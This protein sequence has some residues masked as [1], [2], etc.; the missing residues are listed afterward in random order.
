M[1]G[2]DTWQ[3][4][5]LEF[6]DRIEAFDDVD[7]LAVLSFMLHA[8]R[9]RPT[10]TDLIKGLGFAIDT[11]AP[12]VVQLPLEEHLEEQEARTQF[13]DALRDVLL[14]LQAMGEEVPLELLR[15]R[16]HIPGVRF[17]RDYPAQRLIDVVA[18]LE[19]LPVG[20]QPPTEQP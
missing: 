17:A 9:A 3:T 6:E 13:A 5:Y 1:A 2:A 14:Q 16:C 7:L 19:S 15:E 12:G 4:S 10:R 20:D 8:M 18:R 11:H